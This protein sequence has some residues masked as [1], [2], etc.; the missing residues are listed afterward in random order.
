[1]SWRRPVFDHATFRPVAADIY[2]PRCDVVAVCDSTA[3]LGEEK[4]FDFTVG[5][6]NN[7]LVRVAAVEAERHL[8]L[9]ADKLT[10]DSIIEYSDG[11]GGTTILAARNGSWLTGGKHH[12]CLW[13]AS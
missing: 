6:L 11:P 8:L 10:V 7:D 1:V 2:I 4:G 9:G 12:F 13:R 5:F 3:I